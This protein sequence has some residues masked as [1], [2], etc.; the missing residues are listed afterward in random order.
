MREEPTFHCG[1][2]DDTKH[3]TPC[4]DNPALRTSLKSERARLAPDVLR[5]HSQQIAANLWRLPALARNK[6]IGCYLPVGG[7]V[8]CR[9]IVIDAWNRGRRVFLPVLSGHALMF[10]PCAADAKFAQ[11]R[12]GIPEPVCRDNVLLRPAQL[13]VVL[14]PL[15]GFDEQGN[16]LGMGG[17]YYDRSF[18]YLKNRQQWRHPLLIGLAYEFQKTA[19]IKAYSWDIPLNYVVTEQTIYSF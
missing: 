5:A 4:M 9:I 12:Y 3:A 14:T 17:G 19:K 8:D 7:E 6:N 18:S 15:V 10:A 1:S 16:R 11:N 13:D 2:I